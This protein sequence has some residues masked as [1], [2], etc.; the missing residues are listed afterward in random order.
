MYTL[1]GCCAAFSTLS[2]L[3]VEVGTGK[4]SGVQQQFPGAVP[5]FHSKKGFLCIG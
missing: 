3:P 5:V 4:V 1:P 2:A